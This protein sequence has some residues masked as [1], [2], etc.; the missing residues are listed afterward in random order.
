MNIDI[1]ETRAPFL[2]IQQQI[3]DFSVEGHNSHI[4]T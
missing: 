4:A 2:E 3:Q 1:D